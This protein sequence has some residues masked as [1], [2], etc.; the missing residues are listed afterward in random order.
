MNPHRPRDYEVG[1]VCMHAS[2][3]WEENTHYCCL[4]NSQNMKKKKY[5]FLGGA[6]EFVIKF[7]TID[8]L[9]IQPDNYLLDFVLE[10]E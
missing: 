5:E 8:G 3:C 10:F 7:R 6:T 2:F 4:V 9:S 1:N